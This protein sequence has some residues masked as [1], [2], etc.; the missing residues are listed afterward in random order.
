M[1]EIHTRV[2]ENTIK[3]ETALRDEVNNIAE[4]LEKYRREECSSNDPHLQ[5]MHAFT[6]A[7]HPFK[8]AIIQFLFDIDRND[9]KSLSYYGY[10][11]SQ[12]S[13]L[14]IRHDVI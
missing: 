5:Y 12:A 4:E 1:S 2:D 10:L 13:S 7:E 9:E 11:A 14:L 6:M 8:K 3:I